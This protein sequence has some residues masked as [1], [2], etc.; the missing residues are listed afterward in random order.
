MV[1]DRRADRGRISLKDAR[2]LKLEIGNWK[3]DQ[4]RKNQG[5]KTHN[6]TANG[7]R[8]TSKSKNSTE[9]FKV[10]VF[11]CDGVIFD[12]KEANIAFYNHVLANFGRPPMNKEEIEHVHVSTFDGA[13]RKLFRDDP[14]S[15]DALAYCKQMDFGPFIKLTRVE[16]HLKELLSHIR[17]CYRTAIATNRGED[18]ESSLQAFGLDKDFDLVVSALDVTHPK[19]HPESL[20][21]IIKHF[22]VRPEEVLYIGDSDVDGEAASRA[23]VFF[24][25]YKN[26]QIEADFHIEDFL[27]VLECLVVR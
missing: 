6:S 25:A 13:I 9:N 2:T 4:R 19:P 1:C 7:Q 15:F 17:P 11:D 5:S 21:K 3:L 26:A 12:S 10:I 20:L 27:E 16:P 22:G 24:V 23:G 8:S 14:Q 18:L